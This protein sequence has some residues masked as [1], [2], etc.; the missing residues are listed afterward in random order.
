VDGQR[1]LEPG[2]RRNLLPYPVGEFDI[3]DV[4]KLSVDLGDSFW[5]R[6]P[7]NMTQERAIDSATIRG[8]LKPGEIGSVL[9]SDGD[10]AHLKITAE[11]EI[12]D[13]VRYVETIRNEADARRMV[14]L[15]L[16]RAVVQTAAGLT[17]Q[18][19]VDQ[20]EDA[21]GPIRQVAQS[22][23]DTLDC[24]MQLADVQLID[25]KPPFAIVQV[26][27]ALQNT[28]EESREAVEKARLAAEEELIRMAGPEYR[29]VARLIDRYEEAE[30]LG[31]SE[32]AEGLPNE[33]NT[34]FESDRIRGDV[35]EIIEQAKAYESEIERT[36]GNE[37]RRFATV[38]PSFDEQP[39]LTSKRL[40]VE[41][42]KSVMNRDDTEII[43]VPEG[44]SSINV[45]ISGSE[46]I[47]QRRRKNRMD[48]QK[49]DAIL[50]A[51]GILRP[52]GT[53][54]DEFEV[55]EAA[56]MMEVDEEGK[57]RPKGSRR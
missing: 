18:Q 25:A 48:K 12:S 6:I 36:L 27:R 30:D 56:P 50:D 20:P 45:S 41:V 38:R 32:R 42:Y 39:T 4:E 47:Q 7:A 19:L 10:L 34:L 16:E 26:Y 55:G 52:Y 29:Q 1:A 28:R 8:V 17:L 53:R 11:Y 24:G 2:L 14:T 23:L 51:A 5:P 22:V 40:W 35:R 44:L 13:P 54:A 3:F 37:A 31:E 9:A 33:I 57:V 43:R 21:L 46:E 49:Q 15:A